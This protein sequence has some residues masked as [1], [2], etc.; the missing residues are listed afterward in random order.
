MVAH[1]IS[2]QDAR[3]EIKKL[4]ELD[5]FDRKER[6]KHKGQRQQE[7]EI[8][9]YNMVVCFF[10]F[11]PPLVSF[12]LLFT[13]LTYL[14]YIEYC[15]PGPFNYFSLFNA[16]YFD[17]LKYEFFI[18]SDLCISL[19]FGICQPCRVSPSMRSFCTVN[20]TK[21]ARNHSLAR[22]KFGLT[23]HDI[24]CSPTLG[25]INPNSPFWV[26]FEDSLFD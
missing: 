19:Q 15:L 12:N 10:S 21:L 7:E 8:Q 18:Y 4:Y 16:I 9:V 22:A 17:F 14:C 2:L 26:F 1:G 13:D 3:R 5:T 25:R 11:F 20:K 24:C 6:A 23:L